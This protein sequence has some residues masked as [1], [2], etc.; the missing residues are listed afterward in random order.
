[1]S[2]KL[3]SACVCHSVCMCVSVWISVGVCESDEVSSIKR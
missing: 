3:P 2:S 1:M